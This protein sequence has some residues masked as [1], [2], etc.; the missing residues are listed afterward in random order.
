M[1]ALALAI[2][3]LSPG[4]GEGRQP[5]V[6]RRTVI[7]VPGLTG[8]K[9][10]DSDTGEMVWGRGSNLFSPDD[11]G[12]NLG[13]SFDWNAISD[14]EI[15]E[16]WIL[17]PVDEPYPLREGVTVAPL[18]VFL[19]EKSPVKLRSFPVLAPFFLVPDNPKGS[20]KSLQR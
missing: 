2:A 18:E 11:G 6:T 9:L 1:L 19:N 4:S 17:A 10:V 15:D 16:A 12:Y 7:V 14:L 20:T 5:A 13:T 8:S 3:A